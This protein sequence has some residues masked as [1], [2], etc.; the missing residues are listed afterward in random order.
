VRGWLVKVMPATYAD[1]V[2]WVSTYVFQQAIAN[3][4]TDA[5]RHILLAGEAAHV[6][7]PFGARGLNSGI[8]DAF[9]AARAIDAA[10][11][12]GTASNAEHAI[13][14]CARSR[15]AAAERN[16]AAS[17]AALTHLQ[18]RSLF[19]RAIR[20]IGGRLAP[21]VP[22]IGRWMDKTPFGPPL[23]GADRDGMYY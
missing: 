14:E 20:R 8:A 16:R 10:L 15:R 18:A 21:S 12:A 22:A 9:V 5:S 1:R 17:S 6:F 11:R 7:A 19:R 2:T 3:Q 4:F 13:Q 23:S